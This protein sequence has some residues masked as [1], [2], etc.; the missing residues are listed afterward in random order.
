MATVNYRDRVKDTCTCT[1]TA[2]L[3]N[4]NNAPPTGYKSFASAFNYPVAIT[5]PIYVA[6]CIVDD[7][8]GAWEMGVGEYDGV[9]TITRQPSSGGGIKSNSNNTLYGI[10]FAAGTKTVFCTP[11]QYGLSFK[12][13]EGYIDGIGVGFGGG[14]LPQYTLVA[15]DG[16]GNLAVTPISHTADSTTL[17]VPSTLTSSTNA[18]TIKP[19]TIA[20]PYTAGTLTLTTSPASGGTTIV[21]RAGGPLSITTGIGYLTGAGGK[22][23]IKPGSTGSAGTT[24]ANGAIVS[25]TGGDTTTTGLGNGGTVNITGG[26]TV[27]GT[28]VGGPLNLRGGGG[29]SGGSCT[30]VAGNGNISVGGNSGCS[31]GIGT[32]GGT[33]SLVGGNSIAAG[34]GGSIITYGGTLVGGGGGVGIAAGDADFTAD[35]PGGD[36]TISAGGGGSS[37]SLCNGGNI[38][39]SPGLPGNIT[40]NNAGSLIVGLRNGQTGGTG[41]KFRINTENLTDVFT[42]GETNSTGE[43]IMGFFLNSAVTRPAVTG[44]RG[45]N[46]ALA[47]LLIALQTL[48]LVSDN[49]TA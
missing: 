32:V 42:V 13:S 36:L 22:I 16:L 28:G 6:Y 14:Y 20:Q 11:H 24:T 48:G 38:T 46:V 4:L 18:F 49:T 19:P 31:G 3:I 8:T 34:I 15:G 21:S 37:G 43:P 29:G 26:S 45:G 7:T 41:G 35:A 23:T 5:A 40:G 1:G 2:G 33:A 27:S 9:N 47:N 25:I 12:N 10:D 39:L 30:L 44:S 17:I